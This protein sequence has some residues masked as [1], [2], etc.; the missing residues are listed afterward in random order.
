LERKLNCLF[1]LWFLGRFKTLFEP[2]NLFFYNVAEIQLPGNDNRLLSIA[3]S[4]WQC[5][6]KLIFISYTVEYKYFIKAAIVDNSLQLRISAKA[7]GE[8]S[9]LIFHHSTKHA[10]PSFS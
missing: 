3:K 10:S 4:L 2:L 7:V 5:S 6:P 9:P 1:F 8:A